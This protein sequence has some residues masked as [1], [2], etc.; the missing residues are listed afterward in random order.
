MFRRF[1]PTVGVYGNRRHG[2][3]FKATI[4]CLIWNDVEWVGRK[5]VI[6]NFRNF[7][8]D[9]KSQILNNL[10]SFSKFPPSYSKFSNKTWYMLN[11]NG[12]K[13]RVQSF[14]SKS[15]KM[16]ALWVLWHKTCKKQ[17]L[18]TSFR[19]FVEVFRILFFDRFWHFKK[20]QNRSRGNFSRSLRKSYLNTC[21]VA[22]NTDIFLFNHFYL[23]TW[24]D[25]DLYYDHKAQEIIQMSVTL[26]MLQIH[27]LCL[28]LT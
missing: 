4:N 21:I 12:W 14:K 6:S 22:L 20:C 19:D 18:F 7:E 15:F 3:S 9:E 23:V 11:G 28:R 16:A 13:M 25:L 10:F 24:D 17:A 27:W 26:S 5:T 2:C 8:N 1:R